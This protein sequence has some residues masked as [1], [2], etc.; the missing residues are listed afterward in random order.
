MAAVSGLVLLALVCCLVA[1]MV[2]VKRLAELRDELELLRGKVGRLEEMARAEELHGYEPDRG[3]VHI[4]RGQIR[5]E[6]KR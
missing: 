1:T 5:K 4:R 6:A 2:A 3:T